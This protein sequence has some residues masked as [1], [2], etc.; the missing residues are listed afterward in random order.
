M[1]PR[2]RG[3]GMLFKK[4]GSTIWTA[5]LDIPALGRHRKRSTRTTDPQKALAPSRS[6]APRLSAA[7]GSPTPTPPRSSSSPRCSSTTTWPTGGAPSSH[8]DALTHLRPVFGHSGP[9]ISRPHRRYRAAAPREDAASPPPSTASWRHSSACSRSAGAGR[10][11]RL[12]RT[13]PCSRS[14]T[15]GWASSSVAQFDAVLRHLPDRLRPPFAAAYLTGWRVPRL[16]NG[17]GATSTSPP[18]AAS[19]PRRD[20]ERGGPDVSAHARAPAVLEAQRARTGAF[21]RAAGPHHPVAVPSGRLT[22]RHFRRRLADGA[23]KSAGQPGRIPHDFRRTAVRNLE[24]AGVPRSTAMKM[25]GHKTEAIY[26]RYAIVDEAMLK[27]GGDK[28]ARLAAVPRLLG[29]HFGPYRPPSHP[30]PLVTV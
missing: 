6:G 5:H 12:A 28:L 30:A 24:R 22:I 10:N 9:V 26:R 23:A 27:E 8:E 17:S 15:S 29:P 20:Q 19:G 14:A 2:K 25:V 18:V 11:V 16:L 13:S 1:T 3:E 21:E 4:P 7:R